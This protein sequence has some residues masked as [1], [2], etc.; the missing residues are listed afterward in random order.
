MF[1][2]SAHKDL[3]DEAVR[4][5]NVR[6]AQIRIAVYLLS[7]MDRRILDIAMPNLHSDWADFD[8]ILEDTSM[9]RGERA[10]VKLASH[11][12]NGRHEGALYEVLTSCDISLKCAALEAIRVAAGISPE[13]AAGC[14]DAVPGSIL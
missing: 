13:L 10:M 11:L 2:N 12:Y 6:S 7:A 8:A 4:T 3:F 14:G 1:T 9:S 5:L